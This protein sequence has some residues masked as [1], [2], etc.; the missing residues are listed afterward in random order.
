M[1]AQPGCLQRP[2]ACDQWDV[3]ALI[4][5]SDLS[6]ALMACD[7]PLLVWELPQGVVRIANEPAA[8]LTERT[9]SDVIGLQLVDLFDPRDAVEQVLAGPGSGAIDGV[10]SNRRIHRVDGRAVPVVMWS[11]VLDLDDR[12]AVVSLGCAR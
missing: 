4:S 12:R 11:R 10:Q 6:A 1:A 9:V 5:S 7:F 3:E 8:R 2:P